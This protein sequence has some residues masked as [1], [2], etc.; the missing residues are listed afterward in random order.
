MYRLHIGN[1][2]YSSWSLRGWLLLD[3]FGL[4]FEE[5]VTP[6][7]TEAFTAL[8]AEIAPGRQVPCL[9]DSHGPQPMV[10]WDSLAIAE[11]LAEA[12]ADV[13]HWPADRAARSWARCLAAE[14]HSSFGALRGSMPMN[15]GASAPG[16][17]RGAG[18][19]ADI[20]RIDA[21]WTE[22]RA[23][24]GADGPYLFG[25]AYTAA[26][27]FFTPVASRFQTYGV[28]LDGEAGAYAATLLAHPSMARWTE[29]AAAEPWREPRYEMIAQ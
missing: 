29:G 25:A 12:H 6:L 15:I 4:A 2:R 10:V 22:T 19:D 18:V 9:I 11:H 8:K 23:R 27:A 28:A 20:A 1:K 7:N 26:D 24:F 21:L 14:M 5:R 3:A 17:G 13:G 16:R